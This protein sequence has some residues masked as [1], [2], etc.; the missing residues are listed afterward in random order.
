MYDTFIT[1]EMS[2]TDRSG[3]FAHAC[4]LRLMQTVNAYSTENV[5]WVFTMCNPVSLALLPL[6]H[7]GSTC[8]RCHVKAQ[9][10]TTSIPQPSARSTSILETL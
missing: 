5:A 3:I 8:M 10:F 1:I 9:C 6:T 4:S 2:F 7:S